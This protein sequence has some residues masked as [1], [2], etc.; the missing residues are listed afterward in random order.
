MEYN[1]EFLKQMIAGSL[2]KFSNEQMNLSSM[3]CVNLLSEEI[4]KN[5]FNRRTE[6]INCL[7]HNPGFLNK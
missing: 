7:E 2:F 6:V 1:R 5:F 4:T 3:S